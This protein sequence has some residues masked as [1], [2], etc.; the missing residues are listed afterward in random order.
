M[1]HDHRHHHAVPGVHEP[2]FC[3]SCGAPLALKQ[4]KAGEPDR[5]VCTAPACGRVHWLDPKVAV[6]VLV[7]FDGGLVMLQREIEPAAGKWGFPGGFVDRGETL[8]QAAARESREEAGIEVGELELLAAF[9][10]ANHPVIIVTYAAK[11]ISGTPAALDEALAV[12]SWPLDKIR[13]S[14]LAFRS[15][16]DAIRNYISRTIRTSGASSS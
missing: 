5:H 9:S 4:V 3:P 7:E 8:E 13:W 6:G 10:Y 12:E 1:T 14:D 2:R 16:G 15:T 11:L